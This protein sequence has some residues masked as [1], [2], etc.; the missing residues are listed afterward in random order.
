MELVI[1]PEGTARCLYGEEIEL[2]ALGTLTIRRGSH[3]ESD[4]SGQW[5]ADLAPCGGPVLG[6]FPVRSQALQAEATWLTAHW[7]PAA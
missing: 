3:V 1:L 7:L 6:P 5:L 2:A 4:A